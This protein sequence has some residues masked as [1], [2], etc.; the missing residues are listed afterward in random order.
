MYVR[1]SMWGV[2]PG[3]LTDVWPQPANARSGIGGPVFR[4]QSF[5]PLSHGVEKW[6]MARLAVCVCVCALMRGYV[7]VW[8]CAFTTFVCACVS[9]GAVLRAQSYTVAILAQA[10]GHFIFQTVALRAA[11]LVYC[12]RTALWIGAWLQ[13]SRQALPLLLHIRMLMGVPQQVRLRLPAGTTKFDL[14]RHQ[15]GSALS[16]A[17]RD[18][19]ARLFLPIRPRCRTSKAHVRMGPRGNVL[20]VSPRCRLRLPRIPRGH[21][22]W[23][24]HLAATWQSHWLCMGSPSRTL[25]RS[26]YRLRHH[27]ARQAHQKAA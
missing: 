6:G 17:L 14:R 11:R 13:Q 9:N 19:Q 16:M 1:G 15:S 25:S 8:V 20:V 18:R 10:F 27:Q 21:R 22:W 5:E 2:F 4:L 24:A 23:R 7:C 12:I 3:H 26:C